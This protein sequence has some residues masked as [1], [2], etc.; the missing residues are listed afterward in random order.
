MV[1]Y[2]FS[3]ADFLGMLLYQR[4]PAPPK[5][6]TS[7]MMRITE[8]PKQQPRFFFFLGRTGGCCGNGCA[9]FWFIAW[10]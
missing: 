8:H 7:K 10:G 1:L 4:Y 9:G 6:A 3:T 2:S 5:M